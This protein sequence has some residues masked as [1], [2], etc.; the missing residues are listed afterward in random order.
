MEDFEFRSL[1]LT[2]LVVGPLKGSEKYKLSLLE[3][4]R[5]NSK[6]L[7]MIKGCSKRDFRQAEVFH[8]SSVLSVKVPLM[9]CWMV[10]SP[11]IIPSPSRSYSTICSRL[12]VVLNSNYLARVF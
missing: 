5:S 9:I 7:L 3:N 2:F 10:I 6:V 1:F 12:S 11:S 8:S 4:L